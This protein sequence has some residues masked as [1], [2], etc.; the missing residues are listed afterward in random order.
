MFDTSDLSDELLALKSK[1]PRLLN[2]TSE[3]M[4]NAFPNHYQEF[5]ETNSGI[6]YQCW[7]RIVNETRS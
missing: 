5:E 2:T 4:F 1:V 6:G 7:S 3:K